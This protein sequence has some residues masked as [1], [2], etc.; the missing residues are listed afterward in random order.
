[1]IDLTGLWTLL[2]SSWGLPFL[3]YSHL[4]YG[5]GSLGMHPGQV[6]AISMKMR[7]ATYGLSL[8]YFVKKYKPYSIIQWIPYYHPWRFV[9]SSVC[10]LSGQW[11]NSAVYKALGFTGVYYCRELG[12]PTRPWVYGFPFIMPHPQY[13][14]SILTMLGAMGWFGI[15][16]DGPRYD[17]VYLCLYVIGLY[18]YAILFERGDVSL[19]KCVSCGNLIEECS[20]KKET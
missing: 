7:V 5:R 15:G 18:G 19:K 14:G 17:V 6:G 2:L 20:S 10:V 9:G 4:F 3:W 16:P 13:I 12:Y 1:M 11:L 8:F